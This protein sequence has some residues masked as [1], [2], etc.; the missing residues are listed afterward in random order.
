MHE[1]SG[2]CMYVGMY[3]KYASVNVMVMIGNIPGHT[4]PYY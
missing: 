1:Q 2:S 4:L 3:A